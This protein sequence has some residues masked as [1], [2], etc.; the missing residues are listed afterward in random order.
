MLCGGCNG[1]GFVGGFMSGFDHQ[2]HPQVYK[3]LQHNINHVNKSYILYLLFEFY[4]FYSLTE[5]KEFKNYV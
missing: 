4:V 1:A 2:I 3:M 5:Y